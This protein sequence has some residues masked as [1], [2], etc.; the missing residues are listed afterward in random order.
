MY[1]NMRCLWGIGATARS[2]RVPIGGSAVQQI[3]VARRRVTTVAA[4]ELS[5]IGAGDPVSEPGWR[6]G[7]LDRR[8]GAAQDVLHRV[9]LHRARRRHREGLCMGR[10][11]MPR[12]F[13]AVVTVRVQ[14]T[15][16]SG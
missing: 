12:G 4:N 5:G 7:A 15:A 2:S 8:R 6:G 11:G 9:G 13:V 3:G 16:A 1:L 10:T 14:T